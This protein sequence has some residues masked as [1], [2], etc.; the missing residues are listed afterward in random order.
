MGTTGEEPTSTTLHLGPWYRRSPFF[1]ATLRA[2]CR[3]YDVYNHMLLPSEIGDPVEEYWHLLTQV[4]L[5]DVGVE[6]IVEITGPDAHRFTNSLT[7]R[8]LDRCAVGQGRYVVL[9]A[10]DGGIVNDPVLLRL[11][12]DRYWLALADSDAGLWIRGVAVHAGL[13]VEVTEPEVYPVQVQGPRSKDVMRDLFGEE[14]LGLGYYWCT[15]TALDDVPVVVSRTGW[16]GE[17]GYEVY[18]RD[19][20]RGDELWGRILRAGEPH[21]I[22]V[23][24]PCEARRVEAGIFNYGS[25]MTLENNPFEV[26]GLE[27]LVEEGK[28]ADYIGRAALERIR[29]RGVRRKLVGLEVAGEPLGG[30]TTFWPAS[31]GGRP[32]GHLTQ[33]VWSPRLER[34]IGYVWVPT[35][36]AAPG[37]ELSVEAPW[38]AVLPARTASLPFVDPAKRIPT[39]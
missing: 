32:V 12:E 10:P 9:T 18:L 30:L 22:R 17:V 7:P 8:D 36:L 4:T 38:G 19:P 27:R 35:E 2:G 37:T 24:P 28:A 14:I 5:W 25:D 39:S 31:S 1:R 26:T 15:E 23:T 20:A 21:G 6:R 11:G 29:A 16:T 13:E 34:N 33:L 3:A